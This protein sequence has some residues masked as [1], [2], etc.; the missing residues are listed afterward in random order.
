MPL[1]LTQVLEDPMAPLVAGLERSGLSS[2][3]IQRRS[4]VPGACVRSLRNGQSGTVTLSNW[5]RLMRWL[6]EEGHL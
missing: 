4:G 6:V 2:L 3:E 1:P 5:A